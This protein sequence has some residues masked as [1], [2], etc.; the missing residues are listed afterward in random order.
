MAII[1]K[2]LNK[3]LSQAWK[4]ANWYVK[5]NLQMVFCLMF[6]GSAHRQHRRTS[7]ANKNWVTS[8]PILTKGFLTGKILGG[9]IHT[10]NPHNGDF[11]P[12][13]S[14]K[15]PNGAWMKQFCHCRSAWKKTVR[16]C[17]Q[18]SK[19]SCFLFSPYWHSAG[20]HT[21]LGRRFLLFQERAKS[22]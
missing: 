4:I 6:A 20:K 12:N 3:R 9:E 14:S 18:S 21:K 19:F 22:V 13:R 7:K 11:L 5:V 17:R 10:K 8:T 15:R 2:F 1:G 16:C